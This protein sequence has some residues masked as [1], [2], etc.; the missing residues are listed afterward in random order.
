MKVECNVNKI[1]KVNRYMG[2]KNIK[3]SQYIL[4]K[5]G[6]DKVL[7]KVE[8]QCRGSTVNLLEFL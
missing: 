6:G 1:H 2:F 4:Q 8:F 3:P 7:Q 5:A